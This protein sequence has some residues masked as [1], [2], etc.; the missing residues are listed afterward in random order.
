MCLIAFPLQLDIGPSGA[1]EVSQ[2]RSGWCVENSHG[3]HSGGKIVLKIVDEYN[4]LDACWAA[5]E[6][7]CF[8][9]QSEEIYTGAIREVKEETGVRNRALGCPFSATSSSGLILNV[10]FL[11][12]YCAGWHWICGRGCFQVTNYSI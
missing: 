7:N 10:F 8:V 6:S 4:R 9:L 5:T 12:C 1:R 2:P 3:V 11:W